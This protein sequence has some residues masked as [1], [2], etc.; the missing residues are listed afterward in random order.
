MRY[1]HSFLVLDQL[2]KNKWINYD[3]DSISTPT[4]MTNIGSPFVSVHST[5]SNVCNE[6]NIP[7]ILKQDPSAPIVLPPIPL[8][9]LS[10]INPRCI[11]DINCNTRSNTKKLNT[12]S[13]SICNQDTLPYSHKSWEV[14]SFYKPPW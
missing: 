1:T 3:Q 6:H 4:I 7:T 2:K 10:I 14:D 12:L 11:D 5:E 9:D 13:K 8:L